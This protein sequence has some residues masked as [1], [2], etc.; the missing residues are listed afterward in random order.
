MLSP[1]GCDELT[2]DAEKE[3]EKWAEFFVGKL[4]GCPMGRK[5]MEMGANPTL[6]EGE[7]KYTYVGV[8]DEPK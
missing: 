6:S 1:G 5:R 7:P 8:D 3:W 4:K 2:R